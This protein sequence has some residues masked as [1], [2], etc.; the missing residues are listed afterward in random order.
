[1][2]VVQNLD[3]K[4]ILVIGLPLIT[5][6]IIFK[7]KILRLFGLKKY[8]IVYFSDKDYEA[9][10]TLKKALGFSADLRR[11]HPSILSLPPDADEYKY[12]IFIGDGLFNP[13]YRRFVELGY[14]PKLTSTNRKVIRQIGNLIFIAGYT[15]VDTFEAVGEFI[16]KYLRKTE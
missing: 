15:R 3:K 4:D 11:L 2:V 7:D 9:A 12:I 6:L 13:F 10:S 5:A 14:L 1:M 8:L 16:R